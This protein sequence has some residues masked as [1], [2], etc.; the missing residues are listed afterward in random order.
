[1]SGET[2]VIT[3]C[4]RGIGRA[5]ALELQGRG[6]HV[7]GCGRNPSH[8]DELRAQAPQGCR[9]DVVDV[10]DDAAVASWCAELLDTHGAPD[11]LVNNAALINRNAP[12]WEV[13]AEEL[14]A[15]VDVN[16]KGTV[17]TIRHLVPAMARRGHGVIVNMSSGWGRSTSPEVAPYCATKWAVEGLTQALA[18]E[19]PA[20]LAAVALSPGV[21]DTEMLQSCNPDM[22]RA[23]P[24]PTSWAVGAVDHLLGL[25]P[26]HNGESLSTP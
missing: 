16:I 12:L 8:I 22:A 25:G 23:S 14:S 4:T 13:P 10:T 2:I 19:L 18:Q 7:V 15:V 26:R 17:A 24:D 21:V 20:G 3:G 9:Y 11:L 1:V 5:L 6:A